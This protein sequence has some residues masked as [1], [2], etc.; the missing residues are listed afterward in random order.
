MKHL[1]NPPH[2]D[3]QWLRQIVNYS[4]IKLH[5]TLESEVHLDF[6]FPGQTQGEISPGI[7]GHNLFWPTLK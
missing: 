4:A 2:T 3:V 5:L 7:P 1:Q 6:M